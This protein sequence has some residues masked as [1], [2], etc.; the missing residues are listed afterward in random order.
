[1]RLYQ[2]QKNYYLFFI[3]KDRHSKT[4]SMP[5]QTYSVQTKRKKNFRHR[6]TADQNDKKPQKEE[7][8]QRQ[9]EQSL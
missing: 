6:M 5:K 7:F 1:M 2:Y 3:N 8:D 4:T 9:K